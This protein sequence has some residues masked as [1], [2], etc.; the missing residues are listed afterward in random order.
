MC[1]HICVCLEKTRV[2][3]GIYMCVCV[4]MCVFIMYV[5]E[6]ERRDCHQ[7]YVHEDAHAYTREWMYARNLQE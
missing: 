1:V 3:L 5:Y 6:K 7:M 2:L 4:Y